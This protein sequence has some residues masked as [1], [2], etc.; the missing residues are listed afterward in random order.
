MTVSLFNLFS[1]LPSVACF[2]SAGVLA[3]ADKPWFVWG[4][5][6]FV[7]WGVFTTVTTGK[8]GK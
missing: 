4:A 3:Y 7:G 8:D 2:V 1:K 6:L 5:F